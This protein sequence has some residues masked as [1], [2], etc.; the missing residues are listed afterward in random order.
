[1]ANDVIW[2]ARDRVAAVSLHPAFETRVWNTIFLDP[3]LAV[4]PTSCVT[5]G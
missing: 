2:K 4:R 3:P 5:L 1:M